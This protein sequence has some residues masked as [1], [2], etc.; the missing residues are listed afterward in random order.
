[1]PLRHRTVATREGDTFVLGIQQA[2]LT[3][4]YPGTAPSAPTVR[5]RAAQNR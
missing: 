5:L 1:M 4:P 3:D 2:R